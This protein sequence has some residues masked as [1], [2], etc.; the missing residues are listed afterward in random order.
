MRSVLNQLGEEQ[1]P[2]RPAGFRTQ[3]HQRLNGRL[4]LVQLIDFAVRL[5]PYAFFHFLSAL[6]AAVCF[7]ITGHYPER[8]DPHAKRDDH[9]R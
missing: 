5:L 9:D 1:V 3:F 2:D 7:S 6:G 8:G 4:T